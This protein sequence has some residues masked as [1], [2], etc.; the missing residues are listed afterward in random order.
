MN[1]CSWASSDCGLACVPLSVHQRDGFLPLRACGLGTHRAAIS[2]FPTREP[3]SQASVGWSELVSNPWER[4]QGS[5]CQELDNEEPSTHG[6][7]HDT[8]WANL[9]PM[10]NRLSAMRVPLA[11]FSS[12]GIPLC[13]QVTSP[14]LSSSLARVTYPPLPFFPFQLC[15]SLFFFFPLLCVNLFITLR[16]QRINVHHKCPRQ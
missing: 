12:C 14:I 13:L 15:V 7:R 10:P 2:S 9:L 6:I 1:T 3:G 16:E 11:C 4:P 8:S 5:C